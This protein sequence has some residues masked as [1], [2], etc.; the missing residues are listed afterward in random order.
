MGFKFKILKTVSLSK[1]KTI[2]NNELY[3]YENFC[4]C[5]ELTYDI[6]FLLI[7]TYK[8][9]IAIPIN[10]E[11]PEGSEYLNSFFLIMR[12]FLDIT[13]FAAMGLF[14]MKSLDYISFN[15]Q[16]MLSLI[17]VFMRVVFHI[18]FTF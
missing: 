2:K 1:I 4:Y 6:L 11:R 15:Y 3:L 12:D 7:L 13:N 18:L 9:L 10:P 16:P 5:T 8:S 17:I 14:L